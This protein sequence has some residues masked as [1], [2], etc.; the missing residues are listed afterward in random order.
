MGVVNVIAGN[1]R[2]TTRKG[3]MK[4]EKGVADT[5]PCYWLATLGAR[6]KSYNYAEQG[7]KASGPQ[8][9]RVGTRQRQIGLRRMSR[10]ESKR[11]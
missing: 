5:M 6:D 7:A 2:L 4:P 1:E 9:Q 8:G 10:T 3:K 11:D